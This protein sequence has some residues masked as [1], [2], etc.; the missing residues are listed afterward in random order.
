[1]LSLDGIPVSSVQGSRQANQDD[2]S[3]TLAFDSLI[4]VTDFSRIFVPAP[5]QCGNARGLFPRLG[6]HE[7][8]KQVRSACSR[9]V[10]QAEVMKIKEYSDL[11]LM[12]GESFGN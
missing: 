6:V 1:M 2:R 8:F 7:R 3:V 10:P 12:F 9:Y 4:K 5:Y 11:N